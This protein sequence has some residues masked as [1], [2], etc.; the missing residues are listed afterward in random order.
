MTPKQAQ[1]IAAAVKQLQD[2]CRIA[3]EAVDQF[4][5]RLADIEARLERL[6]QPAKEQ[7]P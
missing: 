3:V 4:D 6:E 7:T 1:Q 5:H 2:A